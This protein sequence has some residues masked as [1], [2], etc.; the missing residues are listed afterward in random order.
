MARVVNKKD[1]FW[2]KKIY[3]KIDQKLEET[4]NDAGA[5]FMSHNNNL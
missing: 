2:L 5:Q 1:V 4:L 3:K